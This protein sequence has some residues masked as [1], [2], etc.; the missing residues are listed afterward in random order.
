MTGPVNPDTILFDAPTQFVEDNSLIPAGTV[1]K[2]QYGFSQT[3]GGPYMKLFDDTDLAPTPQGKQTFDLDLAGFAFGQWFGAA[4]AVSKDGPV[5]GW[6]NEIAFIVQAKTPK[7]PA[8]FT[9][10]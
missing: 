9:V 3:S 8:N 4:R 1:T 2:Y 5:S 7:P 10:A 6:S